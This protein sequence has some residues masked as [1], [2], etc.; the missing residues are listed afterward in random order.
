MRKK[1]A[2]LDA[3]AVSW[4]NLLDIIR[5]FAHKLLGRIVRGT[6]TVVGAN[7]VTRRVQRVSARERLLTAM[8]RS[9]GLHGSHLRRRILSIVQPA[10]RLGAVVLR[11]AARVTRLIIEATARVRRLSLVEYLISTLQVRLAAA[12]SVGGS[13]SLWLEVIS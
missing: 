3:A 2:V 9:S 12:T 10:L 6:A 5:T 7:G 8:V 11:R 1:I 4:G 13:G